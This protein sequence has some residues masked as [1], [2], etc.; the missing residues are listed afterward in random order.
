ME[1][2]ARNP[3]QLQ[4]A[5]EQMVEWCDQKIAEAHARA[6]ECQERLT[7]AVEAGWAAKHLDRDLALTAKQVVF[8]TKIKAA[9]SEGYY[10]IPNFDMSVFAIRTKAKTPSGSIQ[11]SDW[12]G[13]HQQI[14]GLLPIGEGRYV[15]PNPTLQKNADTVTEKDSQGRERHVT[16]WSYW[17]EEFKEVSFPF[18]MAKPVTMKPVAQAMARKLFDEIG[19]CRNYRRGRRGD[20]MILGAIRNPKANKPDLS[21]FI[22]WAFNPDSL[23]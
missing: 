17:P 23:A 6:L 21:F 20:P 12:A 8:Y 13:H 10:I 1:L 19:I 22:T 9:L 7:I 2:V 4:K 3:Y 15:S 16:K 14:A 5:H 11:S 18:D